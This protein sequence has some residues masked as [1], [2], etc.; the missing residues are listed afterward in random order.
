[1]NKK[2][3]ITVQDVC[4]YEKTIKA[5]TIRGARTLALRN[6]IEYGTKEWKPLF[7]GN[8]RILYVDTLEDNK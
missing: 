1:M 4:T 7:K 3:V 2:Y 8:T 6:I 5:D